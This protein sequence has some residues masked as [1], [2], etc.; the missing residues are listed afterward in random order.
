MKQL[1]APAIIAK[2][3][4]KTTADAEVDAC[5][6]YAR[7]NAI[8]VIA[9][10][11]GDHFQREFIMVAQEHRPLA[12]LWNWRR[13]FE[14]INDRN[15][16]LHPHSHENSRHQWEMECHVALV[17]LAAAEVTNSILGPLVRFGE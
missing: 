1:D 13:L 15:T 5:L 14:D 10:F 9:F 17:S 3:R 4:R 8:H 16:V 2:Q 11:V 7:V 6:R 12:R